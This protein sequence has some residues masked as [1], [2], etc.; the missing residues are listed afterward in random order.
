MWM[1]LWLSQNSTMCMAVAIPC[2]MDLT[3]L[4]TWCWLERNA[5]CSGTETSVKVVL[6]PCALRTPLSTW[7]KWTP[8]ALYKPVWK[9][10]ESW[11]RNR[12]LAKLM[13]L[14]PLPV[15]RIFLWLVIWKRWR[16]TPLCVTLV[17]LITRLIWLAWPRSLGSRN[18]SLRIWSLDGSSRAEKVSWCWLKVDLW[19]WVVPLVILLSWWATVSP[20]RPLP[21]SNY[22]KIK[23]TNTKPKFINFQKSSMKK[24][25]DC[26]LSIW[27]P[28]LLCCPMN[29]L[30][31]SELS[32]TDLSNN[33]S[34]DIDIYFCIN[35]S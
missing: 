13:S 11:P 32:R 25:P 29:K 20:I 3:E 8:S 24:S 34:T 14:W 23:T 28:L 1:T 33:L 15:I 21:K 12:S 7:L 6:L 4:V 18:R 26:T 16:T 31:I 35:N 2:P 17:T 30:N 22:G 9:A 27:M 10:T 19:I 5:L